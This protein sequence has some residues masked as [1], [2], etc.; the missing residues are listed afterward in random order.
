MQPISETEAHRELST[1][2]HSR[3][4]KS[5][6]LPYATSPIHGP[7]ESASDDDNNAGDYYSSED[8]ESMFVKSLPSDFFLKELS[9][10]E[11]EIERQDENSVEVH[12]ANVQVTEDAAFEP[13]A[14]IEP[15]DQ[16]Q[17][18]IKLKEINEEWEENELSGGNHNDNIYQE[19]T[20]FE[21]KKQR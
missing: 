21:N 12:P 14:C 20:H 5:L 15:K 8:E 17:I 10:S 4:M 3:H 9:G 18:D 13:S 2:T 16:K 19:L 6:S 11:P 7:E 1:N